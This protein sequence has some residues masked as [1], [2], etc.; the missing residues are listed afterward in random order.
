MRGISVTYRCLFGSLL[1]MCSVYAWAAGD[2]KVVATLDTNEILIGDW[3]QLTLEVSHSKNQIV[4]WPIIEDKIELDSAIYLEIINTSDIDTTDFGVQLKL[5][6]TYTM[7]VFDSG[8]YVILPF[9]V[10]F[11]Q[12]GDDDLVTAKTD[13]L[14]LS[15]YNVE[16]D[17][18]G[19]IKPIKGPLDMPFSLWEIRNYLIIGALSLMVIIGLLYFFLT[20]KR[21]EQ[22]VIVKKAPERPAHLIALEQ[23]DRLDSKKLWQSE[24]IKPYHSE[25]S[26]IV[27]EYIERRYSVLALESTT[28]EIIDRMS[29][30]SL[31]NQHRENLTD[32]LRL[33]DFVKFAKVRPLPDDHVRSMKL[34]YEFVRGTMV[35]DIETT[36]IET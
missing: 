34:A 23:L 28:D 25:L 26:D 18:A 36:E 7:T 8:H 4:I 12:V 24:E 33:A 31:D 2:N 15:V 13:S 17:A 19:P 16:V 6:R 14:L 3:I 20:R 21:Q 29:R 1:L 30:I 32:I 9:V 22:P 11:Q 5:T 27:R 10:Q 35:I